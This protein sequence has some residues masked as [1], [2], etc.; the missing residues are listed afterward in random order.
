MERQIL[1]ACLRARPRIPTELGCCNAVSDKKALTLAF[2]G[3]APALG[4]SYRRRET[5]PK[6]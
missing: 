1:V 4:R 5:K 2:R 6:L 3:H